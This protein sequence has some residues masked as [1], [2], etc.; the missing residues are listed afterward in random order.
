MKELKTLADCNIEIISGQIMSRV[1]AKP[2]TGD[3]IIETRRVIVPKA[4]HSDG[5]VDCSELPQE[6]LRTEADKKRITQIGDIVIKLST[7]YDAAIIDE[8]SA[9]CIV[10]SFCAIIRHDAT[11]DNRYLLAFL[12]SDCCKD[13][14]KQ[15]VAGA[16]MTVL[17][18]G[19]V[20][21][22]LIPLATCEEQAVIGNRFIET[23]RK[24][25]I[26]KE[27]FE[28]ETKRNDI[29]FRDLVEKR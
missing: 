22:V 12:N 18:V 8:Y 14:L 23:Q 7:P 2:E 15:Q 27:I 28:L 26:L 13:Q 9:G 4:I 6:T 17:S 20:S 29:V 3:E 21:S 11:I 25:R 10:P 19:K 16:V 1:T 5:T 24:I